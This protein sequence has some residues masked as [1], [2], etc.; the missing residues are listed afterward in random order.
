MTA[1]YPERSHLRTN[2]DGVFLT[3]ISVGLL[4]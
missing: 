1:S 2:F 3:G 4:V